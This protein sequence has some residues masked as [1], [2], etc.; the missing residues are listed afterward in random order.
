MF[1]ALSEALRYISRK[2]KF[3]Y[4]FLV[5]LRALTG[6]LDVAG[7]ALIGIIA[8]LASSSFGNS[9]PLVIFGYSLPKVTPELL[10]ALVVLVLVLFLFKAIIAIGLG[11]LITTFL[12]K[13]ETEKSLEIVRYLFSGGLGL[14]KGLSKGEIFW[15]V[16]GSVATAFSGQLVILS[17]F[18]SEGLL[19][20]LVAASFAVVDPIAALFVVVYFL[21][22]IFILQLAISR[23]LRVA[24]KDAA[25]GSVGSTTS[26]DD[27][28]TAYRE[29]TVLGKSP[30]FFDKF[31]K[32]RTK[33]AHANA[34]L[35]FLAGL[36]RYVVETA[37][38]LGVV[39]FVGVQFL[40][41]NLTSGFV[42]V[43]VFLT[44][45]V[46]I[47]ASLLPL[48]AAIANSKSYTEQ[49]K[50]GLE[51]YTAAQAEKPQV[52]IH[53]ASLSTSSIDELSE[54]F[55]FAVSLKNVS[56]K[57]P[58]SDKFALSDID[59]DIKSGQHVAIIGPSGAGK[60]T[61]VDLILGLVSPTSGE[62]NMKTSSHKSIVPNEHTGISYVPQKPG[63]VSGSIAENIALGVPSNLID[64][65]RVVQLLQTVRLSELISS[66]EDGIDSSIGK[67]ADAL[68][69]GQIQRLG[70]ARALY[71]RPKLLILDEA[72]SALDASAEAAITSA[73]KEL[74]QSVTVITI[75]HR[76]ST[77]QHSD[78]VFVVEDGQISASGKFKELRKTVPM[79]A[80]YVRLMSFE[81][82]QPST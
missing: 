12:A 50:I 26:V 40:S 58:D 80:E 18:I 71:T 17:T 52:P 53:R 57:Y 1:S 41:G 4:F 28:L 22:I 27:L 24:G 19:L 11:K 31:Q 3:K 21:G 70:L 81:G 16:T 8:G 51:L 54:S 7:I 55:G 79:V 29:I 46:R 37:L 65:E 76:L 73:L 2:Q 13:I 43:G 35:I 34:N 5:S 6:I 72:T 66:S 49:A 30:F 33:L 25:D 62:V 60:T 77:V 42:T 63:M 74:G 39:A 45:G 67:Q 20:I 64:R 44:G 9:A 61:L 15:A 56:F 47:M 82:D 48:Q 75:A 36:P 38:M 69:G 32:N 10:L 68:S 23:S 78:C 14:V 59:L